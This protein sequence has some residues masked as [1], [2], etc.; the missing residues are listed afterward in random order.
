MSRDMAEVQRDWCDWSLHG[1][2]A[3]F[4]GRPQTFAQEHGSRIVD[5]L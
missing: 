2:N 5:A 1:G 4:L 3:C